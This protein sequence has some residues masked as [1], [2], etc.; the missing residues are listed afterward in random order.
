MGDIA[1]NL[2]SNDGIVGDDFLNMIQSTAAIIPYMTLPGNHENAHKMLHYRTRFN[3][4][5]NNYAPEGLFYSLNIGPAHFV[6]LNS[7][8]YF[9]YQHDLENSQKLWLINDLTDAN[10]HRNER[11][12]IIVMTHHPLYCSYDFAR[13]SIERN[14][15]CGA[16]ARILR[17]KLEDIFYEQGVDMFLAGHLHTYE[18]MGPIYKN[19]TVKS[20]LDD[21]NLH[22]NPQATVYILD[23][24]GGSVIG[25]NAEISTTPHLWNY[26]NSND[27]GYGRMTVFNNTHLYFEQ[28]S[29]AKEKVTDHIWLVK[30]RNRF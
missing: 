2:E 29:A 10:T 28:F 9:G 1:Y 4:P 6:F 8:I 17:D 24:N 25:H 30:T 12:W 11:P 23:G 26:Y 22:L 20:E 27:F 18:R 3:M 5:K 16:E 15:I 21:L 13:H 7:E 14:Y 19:S